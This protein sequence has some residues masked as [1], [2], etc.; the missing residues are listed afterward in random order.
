MTDVY[1]K[2]HGHMIAWKGDVAEMS[3]SSSAG[4]KHNL[5]HVKLPFPYKLHEM[6]EHVEKTGN[7]HIVSWQPHGRAFRVH[8]PQEFVSKILPIYFRQTQ[9]KSFQRQ[10][11]IYGFL[12]F[13]KKSTRDFGSYY[14]QLFVRG[15]KSKTLRM[16]RTKVKGAMAYDSVHVTNEPN[17]YAMMT[18]KNEHVSSTR[19][20]NACCNDE[21]L[22]RVSISSSSPTDSSPTNAYTSNKELNFMAINSWLSSDHHK[23]HTVS[24]LPTSSVLPQ[25]TVPDSQKSSSVLSR[26][27]M[28]TTK[29]IMNT[30]HRQRCD[31]KSSLHFPPSSLI[32]SASCSLSE[33]LQK[34]LL[35]PVPPS[36]SS[37]LVPMTSTV[38]TIDVS[39][40]TSFSST[41][42]STFPWG[43]EQKDTTEELF[44]EGRRFF[45]VDIDESGRGGCCAKLPWAR[46]A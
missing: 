23:S 27:T 42:A 5:Y 41:T 1:S 38:T 32:P 11:H 29:N 36:S 3:Q 15:E 37:R 2:G 28:T 12:R 16:T 20:S 18:S 30:I 25:A 10:L 45:F 24:P 17:F 22:Q 39:G 14:H 33:L 8:K 43:E 13:N 4:K 19:N 40:N 7:D 9:Y 46:S 44:F 35:P 26:T 21:L 34:A 31:S 6:L